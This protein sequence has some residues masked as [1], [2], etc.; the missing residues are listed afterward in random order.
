MGRARPRP[1][2]LSGVSSAPLLQGSERVGLSQR[3]IAARITARVLAEGKSLDEQL[4]PQ[5]GD[6]VLRHLPAR[7]RAFVK[8]VTATTF[9]RLGSLRFIFRRTLEKGM[10]KRAGLFEPILL[11]AAAQLVF[12]DTADHAAVDQAIALMGEDRH[13]RRYQALANA[14]LRRIARERDQLLSA[15]PATIDMPKWLMTRWHR[16][17]G[18]ADLAAMAALL[19]HEAPLDLSAPDPEETAA[20]TGGR[21]LP[22]GTIRLA[23]HGAIEKIPGFSEGQW[24]VQDAAAAL[25]AR[26]L[27]F[28]PGDSVADLCA[29]PGGKTAQLCARGAKVTAFDRSPGRLKRL[30]TNLGRLGFEAET[31]VAD[32]LDLEG[33]STFDAILLDAPC[34]ATGTIR[35]HPDIAFN[36]RAADIAALA[37][38]QSRMLD[39]AWRLLR[40]GGSLVFST[41]SLEPEEGEDQ[42]AAFLARHAD[43]ARR[44]IEA[45]EAAPFATSIDRHGDL[46]ILPHHLA[47]EDAAEAG[48]DGFFC[49][50]FVKPA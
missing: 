49:A 4:D 19:R 22:G 32:I 13:A 47:A 27:D 2:G 50:R 39:I 17:W 24:W 21:L 18:E 23:E 10:P 36:R 14:V 1:L 30:E 3:R 12:L 7:D 8:A 15:L 25:P 37:G 35:R 6:A 26:L 38:I 46:R 48:A 31:K 20:A 16:N 11:N 41:C 43:A 45:S 33:A 5:H 44:P 34:T 29:A 9:R 42:A 40:P 28:Q